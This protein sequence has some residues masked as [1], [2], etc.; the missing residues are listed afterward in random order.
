MLEVNG[1]NVVDLG[2]DVPVARFVEAVREIQ[3]QVLALSGFLT[4]AFDS[5]RETV[6]AIDDAGCRSGLQVIIGGGQIDETVREY[7]TADA[8]GLSAMDAVQLCRAAVL[9]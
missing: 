2:I 6:V 8:F 4:L 9:A 5:M 7:T 1:F 3:P